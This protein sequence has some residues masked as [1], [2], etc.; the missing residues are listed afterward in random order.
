MVIL[1]ST[2]RYARGAAMLCLIAAVLSGCSASLDTLPPTS[3]VPATEEYLIGPG[4][5]LN[6]FVW[7]E[8]DLSA[9]VPVRPDGRITTPLVEDVVAVDKTPAQLAR[10]I[11]AV[12]GQYVRSPVVNVSVQGFVGTFGAQVRVIGQAAQPR[13]VPYRNRLTLLDVLTEVGGLTEFAA[14]NRSRIVRNIGGEMTEIR[15]RLKDLVDGDIQ[16]NVVMQPGDVLII[17]EAVF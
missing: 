10:E 8:P 2:D 17:P 6:V 13:A 1:E 16:R 3:V 5:T 7:R 4:D 12:L 11:E 14:G 9:T 15:V